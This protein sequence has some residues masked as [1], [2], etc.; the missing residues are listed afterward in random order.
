M[1]HQTLT[2]TAADQ[3]T[4]SAYQVAPE[5]KAKG[6]VIVLQEI[7]GIN[8]AIREITEQYAKAGYIAI[9]PAVFDRQQRDAMFE[10]TDAGFKQGR[11]LYD[12]FNYQTGLLDIAA[13]I[14]MA[15]KNGKV[16]VVGFCFGGSLAWLAAIQLENLA[17]AVCYYGKDIIVHREAKPM[18]PVQM[19]FAESDT[20]ILLDNIALI[21]KAHPKL[22]IYTYPAGHGFANHRRQEYNAEC[23]L[24]AHTRTLEFINKHFNNGT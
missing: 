18:C 16:G 4:F 14:A 10:Y 6:T 23:A 20:M 7:F 2:V 19:H 21:R 3:H 22:P 17:V 15:N 9:A 12:Q 1:Q 8:Q 13:C 5:E 24:T 11:Q